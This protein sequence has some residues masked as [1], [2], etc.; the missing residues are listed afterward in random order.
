M[1]SSRGV[2]LCSAYII[3][4]MIIVPVTISNSVMLLMTNTHK[5]KPSESPHW[6]QVS[7]AR[8]TEEHQVGLIL[9]AFVSEVNGGTTERWLLTC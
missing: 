3:H 8:R 2:F 5:E 6:V 1:L 7:D 9:V 4:A